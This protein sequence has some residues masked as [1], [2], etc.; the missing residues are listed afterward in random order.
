MDDAVIFARE[1]DDKGVIG[2]R[3]KDGKLYMQDGFKDPGLLKAQY[4]FAKA[5]QEKG[6]PVMFVSDLDAV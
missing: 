6:L 5:A 4:E 1:G 3:A 2:G